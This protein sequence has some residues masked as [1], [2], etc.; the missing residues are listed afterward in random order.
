MADH[1]DN[2]RRVLSGPPPPNWVGPW[3]PQRPVTPEELAIILEHR[4]SALPGPFQAPPK[5]FPPGKGAFPPGKGAFPPGKGQFPPGKGVPAASDKGTSAGLPPHSPI[6]RFSSRTPGTSSSSYSPATIMGTTGSTV[7]TAGY[8]SVFATTTAG[9]TPSSP[10]PMDDEYSVMDLRNSNSTASSGVEIPFDDDDI[11]FVHE[12]EKEDGSQF[13]GF[14]EA[15]KK[16]LDTLPEEPQLQEEEDTET[17]IDVEKEDGSDFGFNNR[18]KQASEE[19]TKD[20]DRDWFYADNSELTPAQASAAGIGFRVHTDLRAYHPLRAYLGWFLPLQGTIIEG[21]SKVSRWLKVETEGGKTYYLPVEV[22][23]RKIIKAWSDWKEGPPTQS[24][25]SSSGQQASGLRRKPHRARLN[26]LQMRHSS[27]NLDINKSRSSV[28]IP[29]KSKQ[30]LQYDV[31]DVMSAFN[32]LKERSSDISEDSLGGGDRGVNLV[33]A[34]SPAKSREQQRKRVEEQREIDY[35]ELPSGFGSNKDTDEIPRITR[36]LDI[37]S[38]QISDELPTASSA[39]G[40]DETRISDSRQIDLITTRMS[41]S[42]PQ[43]DLIQASVGLGSFDE[44]TSSSNRLAGWGE[45]LHSSASDDALPLDLPEY[46][47]VNPISALSLETRPSIPSRPSASQSK[48]SPK[49]VSRRSGEEL[50]QEDVD[51]FDTGAS[52]FPFSTPTHQAKTMLPLDSRYTLSSAGSRSKDLDFSSSG[53]RRSRSLIHI[54]GL[55]QIRESSRKTKSLI[56]IPGLGVVELSEPDPGEILTRESALRE[57]RFRRALKEEVKRRT[58]DLQA[59]EREKVQAEERDKER[60]PLKRLGKLPDEGKKKGKLI[61][62]RSKELAYQ[63]SHSNSSLLERA[64]RSLRTSHVPRDSE[65]GRGHRFLQT[66]ITTGSR[67]IEIFF[68]FL[69]TYV[70]LGTSLI[71]GPEG[72]YYSKV[73]QQHLEW[74]KSVVGLGEPPRTASLEDLNMFSDAKPPP[75]DYNPEA[76][77]SFTDFLWELIPGFSAPPPPFLRPEDIPQPDSSPPPTPEQYT[78]GASSSIDSGQNTELR[79]WNENDLEPG[80]PP[81]PFDDSGGTDELSRDTGELDTGE[82]ED[83]GEGGT[84]D[85]HEDIQ[86]ILGKGIEEDPDFSQLERKPIVHEDL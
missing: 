54:P 66:M 44:P 26:E 30:A 17:P 65:I 36:E 28:P 50:D 69:F 6:D 11:D 79:N 52:A 33:F 78:P 38:S 21:D 16:P 86:D 47:S 82:L 55:G 48:R 58:L 34:A 67:P 59:E 3:P 77:L 75:R 49:E 10:P 60:K 76:D 68:I 20:A 9:S 46:Q 39:T 61:D 41:D 73:L 70:M 45:L 80:L 22:G 81:S 29:T 57:S 2:S 14:N 19:L 56:E 15:P 12:I 18:Q 53:T 23:G 63:H 5:G 35:S 62:S 13:G 27:L 7:S 43:I 25:D 51:H 8:N 64:V 1:G 74:G 32:S 84:G 71:Y 37:P 72:E 83:S 31:S 42:K 40:S 24:S 85:P 4:V